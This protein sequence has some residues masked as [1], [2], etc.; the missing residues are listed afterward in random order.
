MAGLLP[1]T[2]SNLRTA[3]GVAMCK[4]DIIARICKP[5]YLFYILREDRVRCGD[6]KILLDYIFVRY[7]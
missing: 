7:C 2:E 1:T 4:L 6:S 3:V 5:L